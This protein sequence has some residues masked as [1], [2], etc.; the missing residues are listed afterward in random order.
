MT[1]DDVSSRAVWLGPSGALAARFAPRA[2][3]IECSTLSYDWVLELAAK[4]HARDLRYIDAPVTGLP[5]NAA[6]GTLTL[7]VGADTRD[8]EAALPLL[9]AISNRILRFGG[10]GCGT[11]Y[12]L[13]INMIGAVQISS[14]AEGM[15]IAER[16]QLDLRVVAE[17]IASGQAASPQVVR[18]AR[19]MVANDHDDDVLFTPVLRLKDVEYAVR[20]AQRL[21]IGSP[22]GQ[23]AAKQLQQLC[24]LGHSG[25]N[26]SRIIDVARRQA[27]QP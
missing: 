12:K 5:E 17:A 1:A 7:L 14:L 15:A 9:N 3:T 16:A 25:S 23:L 26:E 24:D 4:V 21:G 6:A 11:A 18:N 8:L 10:I 20:F 13:I 27:P 2:F 19:R 22:F